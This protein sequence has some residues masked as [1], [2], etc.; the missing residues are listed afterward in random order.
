MG[1][2]G[3]E[4]P[5]GLVLGRPHTL[6]GYACRSPLRKVPHY[7]WQEQDRVTITGQAPG[8]LNNA[9]ATSGRLARWLSHLQED[10]LP[11]PLPQPSVSPDW[12]GLGCRKAVRI[13][14]PWP[15]PNTL[16]HSSRTPG[17]QQ[18]AKWKSRRTQT[19]PGELRE[20]QSQQE[21]Q[22]QGARGL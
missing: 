5:L 17:C 9:H 11:A 8:I 16:P 22:R 21:R 20:P 19:L 14:R 6:M 18:W 12:L 1:Q 2:H 13:L 15:S 10:K 4:E 3:H 7:V